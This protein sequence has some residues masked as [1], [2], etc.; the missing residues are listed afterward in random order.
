MLAQ[1]A[2]QRKWVLY[3]LRPKLHM[4]GHLMSLGMNWHK[5][6]ASYKILQHIL[7]FLC[8]AFWA[9]HATPSL[10]QQ[11]ALEDGCSQVHNVMGTPS[12]QIR[13]YAY[14]PYASA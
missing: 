14:P 9:N 6:H 1:L 7:D 12:E 2:V 5:L 13:F 4:Q 3:K 10:E 11:W 8:T